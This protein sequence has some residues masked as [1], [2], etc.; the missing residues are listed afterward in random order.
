M[1]TISLTI[2]KE[3]EV[4]LKTADYLRGLAGVEVAATV[5]PV[6]EETPEKAAEAMGDRIDASIARHTAPP[7]LPAAVETPE[8]DKDGLS[9]DARIHASSKALV[10][11]GTWRLKRGVEPA[12][13]A[14]VK[15]E[16]L[17]G[18]EP[19]IAEIPATAPPVIEQPVAGAFPA[20]PLPPTEAP[21]APLAPPVPLEASI[22]PEAIAAV[23]VTYSE[24]VPMITA[25]VQS[26]KLK[27]NDIMDA[28]KTSG[29]YAL[30][31]A[32]LPDLA[33][34]AYKDY[35]PLVAD[36]LRDLWA[37]RA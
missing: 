10:A 35:I 18:E 36:A 9:W 23:V 13:V 37:T 20:P 14:Q 28:C 15:A 19:V 6:I 31:A 17:Q 1:E 4:L 21:A 7:L 24:L 29:A 12:L 11:D 27:P 33:K 30:G 16:L 3:K 2:P 22:V 5:A 8:L 25:A 32:S 26:K 34:E